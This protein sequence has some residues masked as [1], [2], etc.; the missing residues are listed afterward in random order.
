MKFSI[1]RC[2]PVIHST[3]V[4]QLNKEKVIRSIIFTETRIKQ[5]LILVYPLKT[6]EQPC[7][8]KADR[9]ELIFQSYEDLSHKHVHMCKL[10]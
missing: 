3:V 4:C 8:L 10:R 1:Q 6:K 9:T 5:L 2:G 7:K